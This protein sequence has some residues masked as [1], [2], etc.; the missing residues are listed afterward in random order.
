MENKSLSIKLKTGRLGRVAARF[1]RVSFWDSCNL[2]RR[3]VW[4]VIEV[5]QFTVAD[6]VYT[7]LGGAE[8]DE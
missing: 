6:S 7:E 8:N 5:I 4:P 2:H 1:N 3:Y